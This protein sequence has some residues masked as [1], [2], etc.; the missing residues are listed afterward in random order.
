MAFPQ[1]FSLRNA[2]GSFVTEEVARMRLQNLQFDALGRPTLAFAIPEKPKVP[3]SSKVTPPNRSAVKPI[4]EPK[5]AVPTSN[6][7]HK[8]EPAKKPTSTPM[9]KAERVKKLKSNSTD[10]SKMAPLRK[11]QSDETIDHKG[12]V[13][14]LMPHELPFSPV[15]ASEPKK[16]QP[17]KPKPAVKPTIAKPPRPQ[18]N[19][20]HQPN[21]AVWGGFKIP[22]KQT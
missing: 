4:E 1:G 11:L 16:Q 14:K 21:S 15:K 19:S 18:G 17:K 7:E 6:P 20:M 8:S 10:T 13:R 22:M 2:D 12:R 9:N 3:T 5:P